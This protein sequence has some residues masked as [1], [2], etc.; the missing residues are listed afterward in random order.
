MTPLLL[1]VAF[2]VGAP[3]PKDAKV[4]PPKIEG[5]W[6]EVSYVRGGQQMDRDEKGKLV[7]IADGKI[8][9]GGGAEEVGYKLD[10]KANP[11]QIDLIPIA[12]PGAE[13]IPGIY[14]WTATRS[15]SAS[16]KAAAPSDRPDS[17][18]RTGRGLSCSP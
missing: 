6:V 9:M 16:R 17:S 1:A 8:S 15:S 13:P 7:R 5:D 12:K 4:D 3:G 11:P 14:K 10:P 2:A 18:R